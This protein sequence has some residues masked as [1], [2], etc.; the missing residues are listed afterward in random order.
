M[1]AWRAG[2]QAGPGDGMGGR[3]AVWW[4]GWFGAAGKGEDVGKVLGLANSA[5]MSFYHSLLGANILH[6]MLS[7]RSPNGRK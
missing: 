4:S 2:L 3:A 5:G 1:L 7:T 6:T